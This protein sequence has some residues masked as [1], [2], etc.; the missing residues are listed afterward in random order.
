MTDPRPTNG[1][2][3]HGGQRN[4]GSRS[5]QT[6]R[7]LV[8]LAD[9]ATPEELHKVPGTAQMKIANSRDF[10]E[11]ADS[12][13][14]LAADEGIVFDEIGVAVMP[15]EP[16]TAG[17]MRGAAASSPAILAVEP[18]RIL[19]TMEIGEAAGASTPGEYL[20]GYRDATMRLIDGLLSNGAGREIEA[21]APAPQAF[22][23]SRL[24][25][26]LQV[27]NAAASTFTGRGVRVAV[28]DTGLDLTHPDFEGRTLVAKSF[29]PNESVQD[30]HGHGTHCA[31]TAAG[32]KAP[33]VLPRYGVA[34]DAALFIGKVL[35][36]GGS[37]ADRGILA[38]IDWAVRNRCH[39]ISMSLGANVAPGDPFSTVYET[40]AKRAMA[41]GSLIVAAAGNASSRPGTI[42]PVSHPANCP[43]IM[44]VA[45]LDWDLLV[46]L[47]SC[48]GINPN[49]GQVDI[50]GP[51]VNVY[52]S[53]KL[54]QEY[55]RL[56]GT[57]MATPHVAGIAALLREANPNATAADLWSLLVRG[58]MR[59]PLPST[60]VGAGLVQAPLS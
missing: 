27:T 8:L 29:V 38:G 33:D 23:E 47:F 12:L 24:T 45:A 15:I 31:G 6:G 41:K 20:R 22:N 11:D 42:R 2:A 55:R 44:A 5:S 48:G 18:E 57:S 16:Q 4:G 56:N 26:G 46:A 49:G 17:R 30:G 60:D 10:D 21:R 59:L 40:A 35:S 54:P 7:Y 14:T 9:G 37:G 1:N 25:W 19:H 3:G 52:S 58:A 53:F 13:S 51:G 32:T 28:L 39:V 36:N 43:S 34:P 50:A